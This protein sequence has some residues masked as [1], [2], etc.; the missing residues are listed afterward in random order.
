ME[1]GDGDILRNAATTTRLAIMLEHPNVVVGTDGES[2]RSTLNG[3]GSG[4]AQKGL[5]YAVHRDHVHGRGCTKTIL[6]V[7]HGIHRCTRVCDGSI[8]GTAERIVNGGANRTLA[9]RSCDGPHR[10]DRRPNGDADR[11]G[12]RRT[13]GNGS[14]NRDRSSGNELAVVE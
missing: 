6:P 1:H 10:K 12:Y 3:L 8:D 11:R 5:G 4:S 9:I 2:L 13:A 7:G 14:R